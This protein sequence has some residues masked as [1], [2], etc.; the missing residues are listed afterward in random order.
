MQRI[1]TV[2]SHIS[3]Q[4]VCPLLRPATLLLVTNARA[5]LRTTQLLFEASRYIS[6]SSGFDVALTLIP[7]MRLAFGNDGL[8]KLVGSHQVCTSIPASTAAD[9]ECLRVRYGP[10]FGFWLTVTALV[11]SLALTWE[12]TGLVH[13][14]LHEQLYPGDTPPTLVG[15]WR[16]RTRRRRMRREDKAPGRDDDDDAPSPPR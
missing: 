6:Y 16:R 3:L 15:W 13:D 11:V 2:A 14:A 10:E 4:V 9:G 5:S 8:S 12:P 7:L 1:L